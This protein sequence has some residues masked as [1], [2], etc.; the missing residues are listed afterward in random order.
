MSALTELPPSYGVVSHPTLMYPVIYW[1]TDE[2]GEVAQPYCGGGTMYMAART[3]RKIIEA[4]RLGEFPKLLG[5]TDA[6][7]SEI[8]ADL[9]KRGIE[10]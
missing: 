5:I 10:L 1:L 6:L 3:G 9:A 8:D 2:W 7:R 4:C